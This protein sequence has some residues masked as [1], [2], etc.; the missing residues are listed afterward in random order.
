MSKGGA[1]KVYF[2]LYLAV[3]LEL[4]IIIV[5][6]DEAE[7]HLVAKQK[8][9]MSIV[10]NILGQLQTGGGTEGIST[11]ARDEITIPENGAE[12]GE[13]KIRQDREFFIEI[14][15]NDL[16]GVK[17]P[18]KENKKT[19]VE[20]LKNLIR[21]ANVQELEYQIFFHKSK[22][23]YVPVFPS[24]D[25]LNSIKLKDPDQIVSS[26]VDGDMWKLKFKRGLK[27]NID[28][29]MESGGSKEEKWLYPAYTKMPDS[30]GSVKGFAPDTSVAKDNFFRYSA[31]RTDEM[32]QMNRG[33]YKKKAFYVHFAAPSEEAGWYKLRFYSKTNK[34]LGVSGDIKQG[35]I[36]PESEVS[37]G[38][39]KLKVKNLQAV[40][41]D[42]Y[43]DEVISKI[44]KIDDFRKAVM[45]AKDDDVRR[46]IVRKFDAEIDAELSK[47]RT[48]QA[49]ASEK[50]YLEITEQIGNVELYR[51]IAKLL[52]PG[53]SDSFEQNRAS[54]QIDIR[55][56]K[57][58]ADIA[59]PYVSDIDPVYGFDQARLGFTFSSGPFKGNNLP[60]AV[61]K[62]ENGQETPL[63]IEPLTGGIA[64]ANQTK[65]GSRTYRALASKS[66]PAGKYT[67]KVTQ[68]AGAKKD[69]KEAQAQVFESDLTDVS[70]GAIESDM[71]S[72]LFYGLTFKA[73]IEPKSGGRIKSGE[74]EVLGRIVG[75]PQR[76]Y[77]RGLNVE[78]PLEAKGS[79][80]EVSVI[81][82]S[83][84]TG[85]TVKLFRKTSPIMQS[86]P[87]INIS[88]A[89]VSP[90]IQRGGRVKVKYQGI[91]VTAPDIG[92][93]ESA[94][95]KDMKVSIGSATMT[96]ENVE[97][98]SPPTLINNGDGSYSIE[99][100]LKVRGR[101]RDELVV[102]VEVPITATVTN[103]KTGTSADPAKKNA[104]IQVVIPK[105][106]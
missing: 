10:Q 6:R 41:R 43:R 83:P 37:I 100:D 42:L 95:A 92:I 58:P 28:A 85:D 32:A 62:S 76:G 18:D 50:K 61:I 57:P 22:S 16:F 96:A 15:V 55:V 67:I 13:I 54:Y 1:G 68:S 29:T 87:V 24:D 90:E 51:Y 66:L 53:A 11:R 102:K 31:T 23:E 8:E 46:Q 94:T 72:Y 101:Q 93:N 49:T 21:L 84:I 36:D 65:G 4:L 64:S 105:Q 56:I 48:D 38:T 104:M 88:S 60:T 19:Y 25:S 26:E 73:T 97:M 80:L 30:I 75:D 9:T 52:A 59:Q 86:P 71:T 20:E 39:V 47:L 89:R 35:D 34:I 17:M 12:K 27:L 99:F 74:F 79:Q 98:E 82:V 40:G 69:T 63:V 5:E 44:T 7:E 91:R 106:R 3:I 14:G 70:K 77:R 2:V 78:V 33:K 81:W 45:E 103:P